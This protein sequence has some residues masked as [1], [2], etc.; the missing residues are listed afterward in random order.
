MPTEATTNSVAAEVMPV[1]RLP[2]LCRMEPAPM[3]PMP[4]MICAAIR[5]W[6]PRYSNRQRIREQ[7]KHRSTE[8]D[9]EIRTQAGGAM[10]DL[11]LQPDGASQERSQHQAQQGNPGRGH[12][13]LQD[14]VDVLHRVAWEPGWLDFITGK[15][16]PGGFRRP[17]VN[18]DDYR[19]GARV[20]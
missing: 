5:V 19:D 13:T 17:Q 14:F 10:L 16:G 6:S 18:A 9:K 4:G 15:L 8:T 2:R 20:R 7:R 1:T 12:F 11:A 3:N